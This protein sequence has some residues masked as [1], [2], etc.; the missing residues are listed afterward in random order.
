MS[1]DGNI[2]LGWYSV[3]CAQKVEISFLP[4]HE[5]ILYIEL[6]DHYRAFWAMCNSVWISAGREE[7]PITSFNADIAVNVT[8]N[9]TPVAAYLLYVHDDGYCRNGPRTI[10]EGGFGGVD[11]RPDDNHLEKYPQIIID[12]TTSSLHEYQICRERKGDVLAYVENLAV[13][14]EY[15]R[16]GYGTLCLNDAKR[17]AKKEGATVL[18]LYVSR[19]NLKKLFNF[20][21]DNGFTYSP[22]WNYPEEHIHRFIIRL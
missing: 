11:C 14:K 19:R 3:F 21:R 20:Y 4:N 9:G 6:E 13:S 15:Q 22:L 2:F 17:L 8:L 18:A 5:N 1:T 7:V 16:Q 10:D 12:Y